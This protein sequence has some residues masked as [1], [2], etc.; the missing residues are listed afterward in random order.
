MDHYAADL[1]ALTEALDLRDAIHAGHSTGGDEVAA[2]V[3]RHGSART[4]KVVLIGAMP[5][6]WVKNANNP[7][8]APLEVFDGFGKALVVM[9]RGLR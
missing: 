1:A 5:P 8:G 4:A 2:Y 3:A 9:A 6:I 7:D